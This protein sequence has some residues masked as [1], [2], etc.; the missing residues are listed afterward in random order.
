MKHDATSLISQD[1]PT[2]TV[3]NSES[4]TMVQRCSW[5]PQDSGVAGNGKILAPQ[6]HLREFSAQ[7]GAVFL[8]Q[9][10]IASL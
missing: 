4:C 3:N 8:A 6:K 7:V 9:L 1:Y 10:F 2:M 5:L